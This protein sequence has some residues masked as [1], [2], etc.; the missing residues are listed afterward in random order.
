MWFST[1]IFFTVK[2][3][4]FEKIKIFLHCYFYVCSDIPYLR[5]FALNNNPLQKI[6]SNAFEMIPQIVSLDLSGEH[7]LC[8]PT[9]MSTIGT[10]HCMEQLNYTY[11]YYNRVEDMRS[12]FSGKPKNLIRV[13]YNDPYEKLN[14]CT[15]NICLILLLLPGVYNWLISGLF[16]TYN[17]FCCFYLGSRDLKSGLF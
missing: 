1:S 14:E 11:V 6:E 5:E 10:V 15:Y 12:Y 8:T 2:S 9:N 7:M 17:R 16:F 4:P 13:L 3:F